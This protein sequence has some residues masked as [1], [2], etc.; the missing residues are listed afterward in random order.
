VVGIAGRLQTG[1]N[2][3][4][5][6]FLGLISYSLYLI[7]N[8]VTGA[9]FRIGFILTGRS[10]FTEVLWWVGSSSSRPAPPQPSMP[11]IRQAILDLFARPPP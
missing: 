4:W 5:L 1:L 6:Q 2:W 11:A 7:H 9:A 10:V 3:R 8:L